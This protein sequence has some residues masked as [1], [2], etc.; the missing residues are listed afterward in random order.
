MGLGMIRV[1]LGL[2][3]KLPDA[4]GLSVNVPTCR[5]N[6]SIFAASI[7]SFNFVRHHVSCRFTFILDRC[8]SPALIKHFNAKHDF[9]THAIMYLACDCN[10]IHD[11]A[12]FDFVEIGQFD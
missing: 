8:R 7:C 12:L 2:D 4:G 11:R 3:V 1:D 9:K 6:K 5:M 10:Y